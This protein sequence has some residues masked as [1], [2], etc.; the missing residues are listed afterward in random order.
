MIEQILNIL[1][2][3]FTKHVVHGIAE[4]IEESKNNEQKRNTNSNKSFSLLDDDSICSMKINECCIAC[5]TCM[6]L[7]PVDAISVGEPYVIDNDVCIDC[8]TCV[9]DCPVNAIEA[10]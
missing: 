6:T 2:S 9:D 5:G 4:S 8:G 7:C 3:D 10:V 1:N